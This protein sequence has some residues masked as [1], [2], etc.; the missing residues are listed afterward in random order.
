MLR[1]LALLLSLVSIQLFGMLPAGTA[2]PVE[3]TPTV[4]KIDITCLELQDDHGRWH[5]IFCGV[6]TVDLAA[7]AAGEVAGFV[8]IGNHVPYGTYTGIRIS[9]SGRFRI[10]A[11]CDDTGL[12]DPARTNSANNGL[13][14]LVLANTTEISRA[15]QD[16]A[17]PVEQE[18]IYPYGLEATSALTS[19]GID[20]VY[21]PQSVNGIYRKELSFSKS[22]GVGSDYSE[23]PTISIK[24]DVT[25]SVEFVKLTNS[26]AISVKE[27]T[28]SIT[29]S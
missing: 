3:V 14:T 8:G 25:D 22:Y 13:N 7:V 24:A 6:A 29:E 12:G 23:L 19:V 18:A 20:I 9:F 17:T 16:T 27:L 2:S 21:R 26:T 10:I 15:T 4:L 5:P 28:F 1:T 11:S